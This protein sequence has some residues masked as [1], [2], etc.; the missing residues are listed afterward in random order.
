M[1]NTKIIDYVK[2]QKSLHLY[3]ELQD[4][5]T[6][7]LSSIPSEQFE[8]ISKYLI[9]MAFHQGMV[10]QVMHFEPRDTTFA[11]MQLYIPKNMPK[12]VLRWVVVHEIGHVMQKRNWEDSD[13]MNLEDN[14]NDFAAKIGY[15][16]TKIISDWLA[17]EN[18]E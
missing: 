11:V 8:E 13:G 12:D 6:D 2:S 15:P 9:I 3:N 5:V 1:E 7:V 17:T 16:K 10:G 18:P 4:A 14:A